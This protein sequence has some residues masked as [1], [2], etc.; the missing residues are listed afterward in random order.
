MGKVHDAIDRIL[1]H[2]SSSLRFTFTE[3]LIV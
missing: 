2:E 3:R 1:S